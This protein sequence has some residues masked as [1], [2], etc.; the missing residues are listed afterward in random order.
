[1]FTLQILANR[2]KV[3]VQFCGTI[4]HLQYSERNVTSCLQE[5]ITRQK[6]F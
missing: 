6:M 2:V 3:E 5:K 1:M 4:N